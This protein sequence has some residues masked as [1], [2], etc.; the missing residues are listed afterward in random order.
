MQH[1]ASLRS[2]RWQLCPGMGG[3]FRVEP[4]A[5]FT[6]ELVATFR[7]MRKLEGIMKQRPKSL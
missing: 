2:D 5:A 3:S 6:L 7:G 4:V 1:P